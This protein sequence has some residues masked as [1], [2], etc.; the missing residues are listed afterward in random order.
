MTHPPPD[1]A[2]RL[3]HADARESVIKCLQAKASKHHPGTEDFERADLAVELA[4][5]PD[6]DDELAPFLMRNVKRDARRIYLHRPHHE[7]LFCDL[8]QGA[9]AAVVTADGSDQMTVE[10]L[11]PASR[12]PGPDEVALA[13]ELEDRVRRA[14]VPV[15]V[16]EECLNAMLD[17]EPPDDTAARLGI[18]VHRIYR[19]RA[20]IRWR[21]ERAL[22]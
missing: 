1:G 15:P 21:A 6:R 10:D 12:Q 13:N 18:P 20:Y 5:S 9:A 3:P 16:G 22:A 8:E 14:V 7:V 2:L 4:L 19:L 11:L 17:Q